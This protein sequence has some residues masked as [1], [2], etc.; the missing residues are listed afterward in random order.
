MKHA[1]LLTKDARVCK[2]MGSYV[3]CITC[4]YVVGSVIHIITDYLAAKI[5]WLSLVPSEY[6]QVFFQSSISDWI[7]GNLYK[8][9]QINLSN[10][11]R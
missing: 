10:G 2:G 8:E 6:M 7:E 1:R 4:G 5:I 9:I 3:S 11:N